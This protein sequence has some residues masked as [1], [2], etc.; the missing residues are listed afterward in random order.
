LLVAGC[1]LLVAG[2]WLLVAL[3][4]QKNLLLSSGILAH[5]LLYFPNIFLSIYFLPTTARKMAHNVPA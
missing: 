5:I 2:C 1:W 3:S 4:Y